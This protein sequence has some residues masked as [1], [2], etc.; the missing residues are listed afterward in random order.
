MPRHLAPLVVVI[1]LAVAGC[2]QT[3]PT[4]TE[5]EGLVDRARTTVEAFQANPEKPND[6]F[7]GELRKARGVLIFPSLF[8]GAFL[9][10][11]EG[12]S[13]VLLVRGA[14]GQWSYPAF[15]SLGGAS[16]GLQAGAQTSEV[17]L[18]LRNEKA[19]QAVINNQ[20]KFGADME[21]TMGN[22]GAGLEGSTTSAFGPDI[23]GIAQSSGLY[24]GVSLEGAGL[25]RR[26]DLNASYYGPGAT[27]QAITLERRFSNPHADPLRNALGR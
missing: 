7:R 6:I 10:G 15:Y 26:N 11:G 3:V 1:A 25:V 2:M 5:A 21:L 16:F 20:G 23:I 27:P 24:G 22:I 18:I 4:K 9:I 12:G 8:K 17:A 14:D 19:V 13:G